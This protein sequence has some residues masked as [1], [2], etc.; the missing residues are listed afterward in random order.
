MSSWLVG[1][2]VFLA[3]SIAALAISVAISGWLA[4]RQKH[5]GRT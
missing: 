3:A 4:W 5:S 2:L 1:V